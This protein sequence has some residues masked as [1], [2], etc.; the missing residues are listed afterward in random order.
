MDLSLHHQELEDNGFTI[1]ENLIDLNFVDELV[2]E[3]K[4]LESRLERSPDNNRF[5]GNRTTRTY[6]LLAYGEIWQRI[7]VQ[8]QVLELI[9]G[10]IGEQ[11]LVSSLASISLAPGETAQVIHADDQVQPLAKPHVATVCNSMWAL[12]DFT[13]ETG[14][15]RVVPGSHR[16]QNPDYFGGQSDIESIPA[17]M[18]KGSVLIW[19]GS[20]WHGGGANTTEDQIRIGIAMNY[21]AGFIRQQENQNLGIPPEIVSTFTPQL[22]QLC[23]FGM[24]RGLTGNIEKH[25]PAY[26]LY[27]D[28]E[29]TQ[30]WDYDP[31]EPNQK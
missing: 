1:V 30:L 4:K 11:C 19:H 23:G 28:E 10:V 25:S 27:G 2:D 18:P 6:N 17:E 21:C 24:Y 3:V 8:P 29:E 22:R 14:A 7:P 31:I 16:W 15:T 20:T 12:T 26:L 5:E 9:E 13:E